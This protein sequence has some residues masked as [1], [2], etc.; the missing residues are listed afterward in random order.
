LDF[1]FQSCLWLLGI[2]ENIGRETKTARVA[3]RSE[4]AVHLVAAEHRVADHLI[5]IPLD[6]DRPAVAHPEVAE[7][8]AAV[9]VVA[10]D[11]ATEETLRIGARI[12]FCGP[13]I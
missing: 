13:Q 12:V 9:V 4:A 8:V 6:V 1:S 5:P 2:V 11:L 7:A 3:A 10:T